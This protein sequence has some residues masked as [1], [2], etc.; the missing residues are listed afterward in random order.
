MPYIHVFEHASRGA[1]G[2][3]EFYILRSLS[4]DQSS[5]NATNGFELVGVCDGSGYEVKKRR[6]KLIVATGYPMSFGPIKSISE[7][8]GRFFEPVK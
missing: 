5:L 6:G 3:G 4:M 2:Y 1:A 7:W 8:K